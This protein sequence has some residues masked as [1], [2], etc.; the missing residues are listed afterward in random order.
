LCRFELKASPGEVRSGM[1]HAGRIYETD[2]ATAIA[3]HQAADVRPLSPIPHAP[4]VRVFRTD[5]QPDILVGADADDPLF[6]YA[7]PSSLGGASQMVAY[8]DWCTELSVFPA[9]AVALVVDVPRIDVEEA[10][11]TILGYTLM[12]LLVARDAERRER[13]FG[14]LGRSHDVGGVLGPVLTTPEE[15]EEDVEGDEFGRR[16]AL[17]A[18]LRVNGVE[19]GRG[20]MGDF[21]FTFA[22]AISAASQ[23]T[24]LRAGDLLAIGPVAVPD[25]PIVLEPGDQVQISVDKLGTLSLNI[26]NS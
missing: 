22:Q 24:T 5:L 7:N 25:E 13:R 19:R 23:S 8:P 21:P 18:V 6:F 1:V 16:F 4:S 20:S 14:V 17:T 12:S 9:V 15:L 10:D 2:G 3:V 26:A 11:D